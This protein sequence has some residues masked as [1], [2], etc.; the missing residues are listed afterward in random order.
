MCAWAIYMCTLYLSRVCMYM[1][2]CVS[3]YTWFFFI[4]AC[5]HLHTWAFYLY[6]CWTYPCVPNR[7]V[8]TS[9]SCVYTYVWMWVHVASI[10]MWQVLIYAHFSL[11]YKYLFTCMCIFINIYLH[12]C[13]YLYVWA[14][15][16]WVLYAQS[17]AY[18]HT[19]IHTYIH[20]QGRCH[21]INVRTRSLWV[22]YV[23]IHAYIHTYRRSRLINVWTR[24]LWVLSLLSVS[25]TRI[26]I[27]I[28]LC[29]NEYAHAC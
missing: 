5:A 23:Y 17:H 13:A 9:E 20:T 19:Y 28:H 14:W 16:L 22:L 21:L 1:L 27:H 8:N 6:A 15:S 10:D 24:A 2:V 4:Y 11:V 29:L 7:D 3:K 18:T 25:S 26:Y 12:T